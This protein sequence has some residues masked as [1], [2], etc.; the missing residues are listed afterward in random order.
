MDVIIIRSYMLFTS[1]S[2]QNWEL[3]GGLGKKDNT[4][5]YDL[6]HPLGKKICI[7]QYL[8]S[9]KDSSPRQEDQS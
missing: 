6:S 3:T 5:S 1:N 4:I 9:S 2:G 8:R 7:L